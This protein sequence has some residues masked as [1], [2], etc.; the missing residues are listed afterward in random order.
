MFI[1]V[2]L[3]SF[4]KFLLMLI[5]SV[6]TLI[7]FLGY[8][9]ILKK[10]YKSGQLPSVKYGFYGD[11]LTKDTVSL[12]HLKPHSKGGHTNLSNLVLAS[13]EQNTKRGN[14][15]LRL[16]FNPETAQRYLQ[17]FIGI[18]LKRFDGNNYV[19]G[20]LRTLNKLLCN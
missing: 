8:N 1:K 18:K 14:D 11:K 5:T 16:H 6:G 10:Y 4:S 13:R 19:Q 12:E 20:I 9:S 3:K 7:S 17:Q 2:V 15:D